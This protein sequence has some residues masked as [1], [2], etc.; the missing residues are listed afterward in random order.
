MHVSYL[1]GN[2]SLSNLSQEAKGA[3]DTVVCVAWLMVMEIINVVCSGS[4]SSV[5]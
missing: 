5:C 2:S 3:D 4:G 1:D